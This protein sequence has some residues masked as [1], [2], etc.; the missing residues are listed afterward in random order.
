V[1]A[2]RLLP[3]RSAPS[4]NGRRWPYRFDFPGTEALKVQDR[5]WLRFCH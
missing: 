2:E 5:W 1:R 3:P 4:R